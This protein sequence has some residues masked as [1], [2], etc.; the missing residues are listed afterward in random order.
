MPV[1]THTCVWHTVVHARVSGVCSLLDS[2]CVPTREERSLSSV[3]LLSRRATRDRSS[4]RALDSLTYNYLIQSATQSTMINRAVTN[5]CWKLCVIFTA[6]ASIKGWEVGQGHKYKLT[7]TLIFR[8]T[9]PA[10]SG[11][12]VGFRLTGELNVT[13][14]WQDH[15]IF[16]LQFQV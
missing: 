4:C 9:G 15:N 1:Y 5:T 8:E 16:L 3:T 12:D 10:K 13:A 7:T 6:I 2:S 11:G 14:V